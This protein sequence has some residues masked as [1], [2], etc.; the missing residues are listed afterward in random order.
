MADSP[1]K[2]DPGQRRT[3]PAKQ[4]AFVKQRDL[5]LRPRRGVLD[6]ILAF[7]GYF[8]LR[9]KIILLCPRCRSKREALGELGADKLS[10]QWRVILRAYQVDNSPARRYILGISVKGDCDNG[11]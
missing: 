11:R 3:N 7:R 10:P 9:V 4:Q 5:G 6:V 2:I 1:V 8:R